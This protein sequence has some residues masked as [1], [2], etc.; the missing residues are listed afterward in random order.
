MAI[1]TFDLLAIATFSGLSAVKHFIDLLGQAIPEIQR[2]EREDLRRQALDNDWDEDSWR[3]EHQILDDRFEHWMPK[4]SA[5]SAVTLLHSIVETQL[6]ACA[7]RVGN[8]DEIAVFRPRDLLSVRANTTDVAVIFLERAGA[9]VKEDPSWSALTDLKKLRDLVAHRGGFRGETESHQKTFDDLIA[10]HRPR[11]STQESS[12]RPEMWVSLEF[13]HYM[14]EEVGAF[15]A[16]TLR[17]I[18]V[19]EAALPS[20]YRRP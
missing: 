12:W 11:L 4:L 6:L 18:G 20:E 1:V 7:E 19:K 14:A 3:A 5:Y 15:F 17:S 16:R 10:R 13:C 9:K 2:R 8:R